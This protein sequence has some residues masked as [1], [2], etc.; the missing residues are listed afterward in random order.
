VSDY[1]AIATDERTAAVQ[2]IDGVIDLAFREQDG[3]VIVD[4]K[5]DRAGKEVAGEVLETYRRQVELYAQC[6]M[7]LTHESVHERAILFTT[8]SQVEPW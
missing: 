3:W 7:R 4:Y 8:D 5:S 2:V 6:W 1:T